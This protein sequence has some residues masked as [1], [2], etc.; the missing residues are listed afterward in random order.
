MAFEVEQPVSLILF[1]N[2]CERFSL[3]ALITMNRHHSD[4][5]Q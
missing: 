2:F 3:L 1:E 5:T 4:L